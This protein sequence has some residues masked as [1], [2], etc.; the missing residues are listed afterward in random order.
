[1]VHCGETAQ[2]VSQETTL[3]GVGVENLLIT[4]PLFPL[5]FNLCV[6]VFG[7]YVSC[8]VCPQCHR[9]QKKGP[10]TLALE[11]EAQ[12]LSHGCWSQTQALWDCSP[13]S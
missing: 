9:G 2:P 8:I 5:I 11:L 10:D 6:W 4:L 3:H 12:E 13:C 1:M 7:L